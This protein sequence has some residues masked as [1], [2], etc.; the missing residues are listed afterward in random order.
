MFEL[1][2]SPKPRQFEKIEAVPLPPIPEPQA[3]AGTVS[4]FTLE[5]SNGVLGLAKRVAGRLDAAGVR[6]ARLTNQRPF[7]QPTTEV[8]YR[9]GYAAAATALA[10]KLQHAVQ[11]KPR[12][13]LA[14]HIDVRRAWQGCVER[15]GFCYPAGRR[16]DKNGCALAST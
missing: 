12:H 7:N 16:G 3:R 11:V 8:Q 1:R 10:S 5:I 4:R 9:E 6:T 14:G 15:G 2:T 13:D